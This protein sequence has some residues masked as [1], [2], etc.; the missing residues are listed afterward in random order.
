MASQLASTW[1]KRRLSVTNFSSESNLPTFRLN[2]AVVIRAKVDWTI[3]CC[4]L[5]SYMYFCSPPPP[6]PLPS[7]DNYWLSSQSMNVVKKSIL[8]V[9]QSSPP[10]QYTDPV[11]WTCQLG[12]CI[13]CFGRIPGSSALSTWTQQYSNSA[14]ELPNDSVPQLPRAWEGFARS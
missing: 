14:T 7:P 1:M 2:A 3:Q 10:V 13:C 5:K 4:S 11:Q 8:S 9:H 12:T 6:P